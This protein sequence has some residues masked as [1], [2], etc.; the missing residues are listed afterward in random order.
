MRKFDLIRHTEKKKNDI[1]KTSS[2]SE[3]IANVCK[4]CKTNKHYDIGD[5]ELGTLQTT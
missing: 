2:T 3:A 4:S 5:W 1:F